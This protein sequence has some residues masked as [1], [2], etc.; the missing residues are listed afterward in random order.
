MSKKIGTQKMSKW[1]IL[2]NYIYFTINHNIIMNENKINVNDIEL[3][4]INP[5]DLIKLQ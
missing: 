5:K 1:F 4:Q 2:N 3:E